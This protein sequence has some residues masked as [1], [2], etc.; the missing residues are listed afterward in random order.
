[1]ASNF[2]QQSQNVLNQK[3]V[4]L[5]NCL[6]NLDKIKDEFGEVKVPVSVFK[7]MKKIF[8][9]KAYAAFFC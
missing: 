6:R 2:N 8:N 5:N 4:S 7:Y 9:N 3:F 1:M